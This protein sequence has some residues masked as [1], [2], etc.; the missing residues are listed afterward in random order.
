MKQQL[1]ELQ[2][3]QPGLSPRQLKEK[4]GIDGDMVK[5]ASNENLYGPSPNVKEAI[6][7]NLDE[8]FY[9]PEVKQ[10]E[11]KETLSTF[12]NVKKEQIFFGSGLDEV[13][14]IISRAVLEKDAEILTS[15]MTFGQYRH[16]AIIESAQ[17]KTTPIKDGYFDL[18]AMY[19]Q[20]T[21][22][23]KLIWIC[24]PNNPTGTYL[25]HD[26]I[27]AF[28]QKVP[29]DIIVLIDEAY[30]EFAVAEDMPNS[31]ELLSKYNQ[32][33]VLRTLSKAYGLAAQRIGYAIANES[34][35][36]Q[37]D[38]VRLPFN[39]TSLSAV[40]A[41]AAIKDQAYLKD[42]T[43]KNR[44]EIEKFLNAPFKEHIY[45]SQT[46]FIYVNTDEPQV[47]YDY[48]IKEGFIT[49]PFP[50]GVRIT[51]GFSE[52]NDK[53]IQVLEEFFKTHSS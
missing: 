44:H 4:Y 21:D 36:D 9:Y 33:V 30:I 26:A 22:K 52:H 17:V 13:I 12:L 50:N 39:V 47:L 34:L 38:I 7:A 11:V 45:D 41:D 16:H 32:V 10:F 18:D 40:A 42:I 51:M 35:L 27:E 20:I 1:S 37:L 46:N 49:R 28:I 6:K 25:P 31:L 8:L 5:L 43:T 19:E 15:D 48:L 24:N 29:D 23:T 3:Y 2:A 53:M 14:M